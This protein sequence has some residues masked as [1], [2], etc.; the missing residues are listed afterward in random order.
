MVQNGNIVLN[1]F[2]PFSFQTMMDETNTILTYKL[3]EFNVEFRCH[4]APNVSAWFFGDAHNI[5][6]V[7]INLLKNAIE[8]SDINRINAVVVNINTEP[9]ISGEQIVRISIKDGNDH[10]LPHIKENLFQ[11]FNTTTGSGLGLYICK[12]ITELHD[13]EISHHFID[14]VGN[15]FIVLLPLKIVDIPNNRSNRIYNVLHVDD[16]ALNRKLMGKFLLTL[17]LFKVIY[18]AENGTEAMKQMGKNANNIHIVLID[19][20]MPVMNGYQTVKAMRKASYTGLIFGLTGDNSQDDIDGFIMCGAD[21]VLVKPTDHNQLVLI[22]KFIEKYGPERPTDK[23]IKKI[24][25]A[26]EW[27]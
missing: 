3:A 4:I 10:L 11:A 14:Q 5:Q 15:E 24:N 17:P 8:Y 25:T 26:L 6:H 9:L 1:P 18:S 23:M 7:I 20:N 12:T 27:V 21:Y 2:E 16:S 19:K 13:G 22:R